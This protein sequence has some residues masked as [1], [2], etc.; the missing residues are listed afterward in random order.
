MAEQ[1]SENIYW[2]VDI[3][4][5]KGR[6]IRY[7]ELTQPQK[8]C[9]SACLGIKACDILHHSSVALG[10]LAVPYEPLYLCKATHVQLSTF[11]SLLPAYQILRIHQLLSSFIFS[12]LASLN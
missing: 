5:H 4:V 8:L 12:A 2:Q 1:A 11:K 6:N 3:P 9:K 7:K 10:F